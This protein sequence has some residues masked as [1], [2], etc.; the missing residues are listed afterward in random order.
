MGWFFDLLGIGVSFGF[1][2]IVQK[3]VNRSNE[4]IV[5][6]NRLFQCELF[7]KGNEF[8]VG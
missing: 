2:V 6:E 8:S 3:Y 4:R 1:D 7:E 5:L